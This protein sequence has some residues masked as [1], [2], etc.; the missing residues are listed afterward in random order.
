MINFKKKGVVQQ[1]SLADKKMKSLLHLPALTS[2][3]HDPELK[4]YYE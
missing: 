4:L 1:L 2:I 3:L